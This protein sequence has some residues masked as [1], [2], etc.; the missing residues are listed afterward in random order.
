MRQRLLVDEYRAAAQQIDDSL[1]T[2]EPLLANAYE[3]LGTAPPANA[4]A[5]VLAAT[6]DALKHDRS[7]LQRRLD[8]VIEA[9]ATMALRIGERA[10]VEVNFYLAQQAIENGWSYREAQ[11]RQRLD[12]LRRLSTKEQ[13]RR[14]NEIIGIERSLRILEA[15]HSTL[16]IYGDLNANLEMVRVGAPLRIGGE[17]PQARGKELIIRALDDTTNPDAILRDEFEAIIHD[18]GNVTLV[19][20]GVIDLTSQFSSPRLGLDEETNSLRD[21]D[22]H[23]FPSARSTSLEDNGYGLRV[24]EWVEGMVDS[25]AIEFGA[26]TTIIG[27]SFGGDTALDIAADSY[28]NGTLLNLSLIHI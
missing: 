12:E 21:L 17:T 9:D 6:S 19:L 20:P 14:A 11:L 15:P 8:F 13:I 22:R 4:P 28:V 10:G 5:T 2:L 27:H 24:V 7:D 25:G 1:V 3:L 23:A 16:G 18:N 26:P